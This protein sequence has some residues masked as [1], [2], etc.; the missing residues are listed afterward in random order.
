MVMGDVNPGSE[1]V[2]HGN[3]IV[4]GSIK[5]MVHAG[6]AGDDTCFVSAFHMQPTQLRI[7]NVITYIPANEKE[8][9]KK[10][11]EIKPEWAFIKEGQVFISA[12]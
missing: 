8:A 3:V 5:G 2:A 1:I 6:A 7:A 4:L 11:K 10:R 9:R 12:L